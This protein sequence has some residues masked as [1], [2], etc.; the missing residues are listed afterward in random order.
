MHEQARE[1]KL[2][3]EMYLALSTGGKTISVPPK[4][5]G[6]KSPHRLAPALT[7]RGD[8]VPDSPA[9]DWAGAKVS[10]SYQSRMHAKRSRETT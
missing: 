8:V 4:K 9:E 7:F 1:L 6:R 10:H 3:G 2:G 5:P